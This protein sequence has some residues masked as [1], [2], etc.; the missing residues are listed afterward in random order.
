VLLI[1]GLAIR[2][3]D[4][5]AALFFGTFLAGVAMAI[6][7]VLLP[8]LVKRDFPEKTG[9]MM[10]LYSMALF[11][12][13]ALVVGVTVPVEH[14][15]AFGTARGRGLGH[16]R[17]I[18][19]GAVLCLA[20]VFGL[21][22][23][24]VGEAYRW[25]ALLGLGQGVAVSLA[26]N[27]IVL[28]SPDTRHVAELSSMAQSVGCLPASTGPFVIGLVHGMVGG[29]T[30]PLLL[31]AVLL[32]PQT[33]TGL[34]AARERHV[35]RHERE[36]AEAETETETE[37]ETEAGAGAGAEAPCRL[38]SPAGLEQLCAGAAP[39]GRHVR[40][41]EQ[42]TGGRG[43]AAPAAL[44]RHRGLRGPGEPRASLERDAALQRTEEDLAILRAALS[45][46]TRAMG[47]DDVESFIEADIVFHQA[48]AA[49][50]HNSILSDLYAS[51]SGALRSTLQSVSEA[52]L[53]EAL[54]RR[55]AAHAAIVDA[56]DARDADRAEQASLAHLTEA[57]TALRELV[58]S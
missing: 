46:R 6:G 43:P 52:P 37:T 7:N 32:A 54:L 44:Q 17:L 23:T 29:W 18:V 12:G 39:G 24:P 21:I 36:R 28:R 16:R 5:V 33:A 55:D 35:G 20:G 3:T 14:A 15:A 4:S 11:G 13:A 26:L 22:A 47:A 19:A 30:V 42:R 45:E 1:A 53:P 56:I 25:M 58:S 34:L 2:M 8:G 27:F 31:I 48:V 50:A 40:A 9:L 51:F 10:G 49:A 57:G 41:G 38:T